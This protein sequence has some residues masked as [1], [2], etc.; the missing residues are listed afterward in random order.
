MLDMSIN[1]R[2]GVYIELTLDTFKNLWKWFKGYE[3]IVIKP[4]KPVDIPH[5]NWASFL[6]R[7]GKITLYG[8]G[9]PFNAGLKAF[10]NLIMDLKE[11]YCKAGKEALM[12]LKLTVF[13]IARDRRHDAASFLTGIAQALNLTKLLKVAWLFERASDEYGY[14]SI[15]LSYAIKNYDNR[16]IVKDSIERIIKHVKKAKEYEHKAGELLLEIAKELKQEI[17]KSTRTLKAQEPPVFNFVKGLLLGLAIG[18]IILLIYIREV[19]K[20]LM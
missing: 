12:K 18:I 15:L 14:A 2:F 10:D 7:I 4:K 13:D 5:V 6:E 20:T 17:E 19:K 3:A 9:D 16:G 8:V 11:Y 1:T